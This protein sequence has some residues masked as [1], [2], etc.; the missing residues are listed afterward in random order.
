MDKP[1][2]QYSGA[3]VVGRVGK[4]VVHPVRPLKSQDLASSAMV[5]NAQKHRH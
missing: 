1:H 5:E 2:V 3:A 4:V